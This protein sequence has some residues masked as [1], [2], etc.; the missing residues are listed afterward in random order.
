[1]NSYKFATI[2]R[3]SNWTKRYSYPDCVSSLQEPFKNESSRKVVNKKIILALTIDNGMNNR[4]EWDELVVVEGL[5]GILKHESF[6]EGWRAAS[7][8]WFKSILSTRTKKEEEIYL[9]GCHEAFGKK[10]RDL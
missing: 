6:Q 5:I 7:T 2:D 8:L 10:N 9:C 1:M 3:A 4:T